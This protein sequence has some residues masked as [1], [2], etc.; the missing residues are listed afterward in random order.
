MEAIQKFIDANMVVV[1]F[2]Y[3]LVFFAAGL[4]IALQ[5]L[6]LSSFRLARYLWL[7][8][9]FFI[10]HSIADWGHVF[11]PVQSSYLSGDWIGILYQVQKVALAV[12]F[13][14]LLLFAIKVI[15]PKVPIPSTGRRALVWAAVIWCTLLTIWTTVAFQGA[16]GETW[17]RYLLGFPA[18]IMAA[19]A[20]LSERRSFNVFPSSAAPIDIT[21]TAAMLAVYAVLAGLIVPEQDTWPLSALSYQSVFDA[22]GFPVQLYRILA[23]LV[24]VVFLI[25]TLSIFD[26]EIRHRLETS[27][28][29]QALFKDRQRIARDLHDGTIQTIYAAG[30]KLEA[31]ADAVGSKPAETAASIRDVVKQLNTVINDTREYIFKLGSS[32]I[33]ESD[34]YHYVKRVVDEFSDSHPAKVNLSFDGDHIKLSPEKVHNIILILHESLGNVA[35]HSKATSTE[36]CFVS[37]A[38]AMLCYVEDNGIGIKEGVGSKPGQENSG[39]GLNNISERAQAMGARLTVTRGA[40]GKGTRVSL[41]VPFEEEHPSAS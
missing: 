21:V 17:I 7:L 34:F 18:A 3:G 23:G 30:L 6:K 14:F 31:A 33:E 8:A 11:I 24:I 40:S 15:T 27:E 19:V 10:V 36:V 37:D 1:Y 41:W 35:K 4:A 28:R 32:R 13:A 38:S 26:L 9:T 25:R 12:S 39:R 2:T 22:T 29:N 20:F 5:Q 16:G